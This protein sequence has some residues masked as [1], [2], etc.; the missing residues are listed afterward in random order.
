MTT[1]N[2]STL[3]VDDG[4]DLPSFSIYVLIA[5]CCGEAFFAM[6]AAWC[7]RGLVSCKIGDLRPFANF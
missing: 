6:T 7:S 4:V 5:A 3:L 2:V 1:R